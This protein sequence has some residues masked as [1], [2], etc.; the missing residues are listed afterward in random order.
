MGCAVDPKAWL[1]EQEVEEDDD[2]EVPSTDR[3]SRFPRS[4][5]E[6]Y[7]GER[8]RGTAPPREYCKKASVVAT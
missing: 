3:G 4:S 8:F 6:T 7:L 1:L 2:D 5:L